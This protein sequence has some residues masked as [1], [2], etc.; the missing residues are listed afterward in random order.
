MSDQIA[1]ITA[2]PA[3][4]LAGSFGFT[5]GPLWH[6]DGHWLFVG[7]RHQLFYGAE[8]GANPLHLPPADWPANHD[9]WG[10]LPESDPTWQAFQQDQSP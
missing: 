5:E 2:A 7:R 6:P 3:E 10:T 8:V 4:H 9:G 1:N